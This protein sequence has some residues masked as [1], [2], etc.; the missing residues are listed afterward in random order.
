MP[1]FYRRVST[2]SRPEPLRG[3]SLP[4]AT[5][6]PEMWYPFYQPQKDERQSRSWSHP[7]VLNTGP[8]D[9]ESSTSKKR[10]SNL[11]TWALFI[12]KLY[13]AFQTALCK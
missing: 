12:L 2:I 7:V 1:S 13:K 6:F 4:F 11:A 5:K 9:W 10:I 3:G 8:V